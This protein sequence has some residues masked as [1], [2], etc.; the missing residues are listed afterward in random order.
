MSWQEHWKSQGMPWR[1]EPEIDAARR[2]YLAERRAVTADIQQGIYP[3]RDENGG[4][5]LTRADVEWLLSTHESVAVRAAKASNDADHLE[6]KASICV[7]PIC[8]V[9]TFVDSH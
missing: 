4:I 1:T 7:G 8:V 6:G 2:R 3:F 9:P 5:K